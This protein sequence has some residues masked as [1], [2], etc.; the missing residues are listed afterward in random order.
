MSNTIVLTKSADKEKTIE[1]L[2]SNFIY[3]ISNYSGEIIEYRQCIG[4]DEFM[5]K[6]YDTENPLDIEN[7]AKIIQQARD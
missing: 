3:F 4:P 7:A 6:R 2:K 5:E 1:M